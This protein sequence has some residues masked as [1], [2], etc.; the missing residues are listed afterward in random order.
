MRNTGIC[1]QTFDICL[2]NGGEITNHH[3]QGGEHP[4]DAGQVSG[5]GGECGGKNA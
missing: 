2:R 3:G 4:E 1:Q 5:E